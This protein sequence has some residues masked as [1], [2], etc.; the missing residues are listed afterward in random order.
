[1]DKDEFIRLFQSY[2]GISTILRSSTHQ[3]IVSIVS[4][5]I[6][7][8]PEILEQWP[9]GGNPDNST[10]DIYY[11]M[12]EELL[13]NID[14]Y[15]WLYEKLADETSQK[16]F[17][18]VMQYRL[19]PDRQFLQSA[20]D[21]SQSGQ[22]DGTFAACEENELPGI[23]EVIDVKNDIK[24]NGIKLKICISHAICD[25]W[26]I[27][28][29]IDIIN[30][31]YRFY[32]RH[33]GEE[34]NLKSFL[35]AVPFRRKEMGQ[36]HPERQKR[37]VAMAP[38][39]RGWTNVELIK[40]CGLIPYI[41]YKNYN[42]RVSMVGV[43]EGPYP[44]HE[45][46]TK[47]VEMEFLPGGGD[48][49][50][51]QYIVDNAREIDALL[52]RGCYPSNFPVVEAYKKT[53]PDGRIY[54]GLDANSSWMDRIKWDA[55][56]FMKFLDSCDVIATSCMSMQKFLNEKWPWKIEYIPNGW[57]DFSHHQK[58]PVFE[59]KKNRILTVGRLGTW[60][61]ATEVLLEAF[62]QIA[63]KVPE[64][65]LRLVGGVEGSFQP[66][67]KEY[68]ERFPYLSERVLFI[69]AL[70]DR[71]KLFE[72]YQEARIFALPSNLEGAPNVISEALHAGCA[73]AVTRFDAYEDA[74]DCGRCGLSAEKMDIDGF[75]EILY[76]LCTDKNL[77]QLC[78]RAYQYSL[79]HYDMENITA[80]VNELL[81]GEGLYGIN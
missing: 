28:R 50:K 72:E 39:E 4:E 7:I 30:P 80:R 18:R 19:V 5:M 53:N 63:D 38:Y 51:I 11:F 3:G 41:L 2:Q 46:Y 73:T 13:R 52:I 56:D 62:A 37:I 14:Y 20:Y 70:T 26:R 9:M 15:D 42:Y 77:K 69:G 45:Q 66:Y 34:Q 36:K 65:E 35:Y 64:W 12:L 8:A 16:V 71:D 49:D 54:V 75:A 79:R 33:D 29:L 57:Y 78:G 67:I 22:F 74:T 47:G 43:N 61:K 25:I 10:D 40:D 58:E 44:Y 17:I 55:P 48:S 59:N 24:N 31:D 1:M 21:Y 27:P 32:I 81:F 68:F 6:S 76:R 60:Q 23:S